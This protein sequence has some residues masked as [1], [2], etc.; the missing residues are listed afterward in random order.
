MQKKKHTKKDDTIAAMKEE[1]A[2]QQFIWSQRFEQQTMEIEKLKRCMQEQRNDQ[3]N[4]FQNL[5]NTQNYISQQI[6]KSFP[7]QIYQPTPPE[8]A[9]F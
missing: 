7:S 4:T 3:S 2:K 1:F 6:S 8:S 9:S 5:L